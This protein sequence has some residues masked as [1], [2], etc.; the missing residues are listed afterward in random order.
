M[1]SV[2]VTMTSLRGTPTAVG[3]A[4]P[5]SL[6]ADRPLEAGGGGL[7]FNAGQL[8]NLAVAGCI[9]NDLFREAEKREIAIHQ[10]RVKVVSDYV[11]DPAVSTPI[12]YEVTI[13]GDADR[14][15][16]DRLVRETDSIA[17]VPNSLRR[18]TDVI[19]GG[20]SVA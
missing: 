17:E 13:E 8:L 14:D 9:S 3:S 20:V 5:F 19:L 6:I 11:G 7:G 15:V 18:G 1:S 16:L 2:E 12:E 10:V 4:G